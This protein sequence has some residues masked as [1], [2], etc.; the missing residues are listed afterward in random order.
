MSTE[1]AAEHRATYEGKLVK[2]LSN[3]GEQHFEEIVFSVQPAEAIDA[4]L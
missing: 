4:Y 1:H 3:R 2:P